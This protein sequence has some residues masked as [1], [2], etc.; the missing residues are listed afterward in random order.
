MALKE[1][2]NTY[3][4][5]LTIE[6]FPVDPIGNLGELTARLKLSRECEKPGLW[7]KM[8]PAL[9]EAAQ[10]RD[11]T[12]TYWKFLELMVGENELIIIMVFSQIYLTMVDVFQR[13]RNL[14]DDMPIKQFQQEL[15]EAFRQRINELLTQNMHQID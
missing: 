15:Q 12:D 8:E 2:P 9:E 6:R 13:E 11:A 1:E 14:S 3:C 4:Y 7:E 5:E 10:N